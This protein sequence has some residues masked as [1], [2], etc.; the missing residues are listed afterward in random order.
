MPGYT[1]PQDALR[2]NHNCDRNAIQVLSA[3]ERRSLHGKVVHVVYLLNGTR[4][5]QELYRLRNGHY[6]FTNE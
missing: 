3:T 1:S 5:T 4:H 2:A 6:S